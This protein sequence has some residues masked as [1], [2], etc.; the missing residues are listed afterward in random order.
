M[1]EEKQNT[2][3]TNPP[4]LNE[5]ELEQV[6]GG[7]GIPTTN[8]GGTADETDDTKKI[9]WGGPTLVRPPQ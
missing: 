9:A 4:E 3:R 6:A 8:P 1:S 2:G 5:K 7:V